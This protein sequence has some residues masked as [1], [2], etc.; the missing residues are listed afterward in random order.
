MNWFD[1]AI[2][3]IIIA[4][5]IRGAVSG[6]IMQLASLAGIVLGAIFAGQLS[7]IIAPRLIALTNSS[8]RIIGTLSYIVAFALILIAIFFVGKL[9][10]SAMKALEINAANR[11]AGAVFCSAKWL[12]LISIILN[13]VVELDKDKLLIKQDVREQA[14]T[15]P[16]VIKTAQLAV[17]YLKFDWIKE[18][19]ESIQK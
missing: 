13:L 14:L 18:K 15:Y 10:Q 4:T 7:H 12:L 8:E 5:L 6:L 17:P 11:I 1:L 2:I 16:L 19:K 9:I 3:A